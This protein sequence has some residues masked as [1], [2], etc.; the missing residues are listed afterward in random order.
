MNQIIP[1]TPESPG[2]M[3]LFENEQLQPLVSQTFEIDKNEYT[4]WVPNTAIQKQAR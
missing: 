3:N 2:F 1:S 4:K